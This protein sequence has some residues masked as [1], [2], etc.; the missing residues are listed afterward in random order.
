MELIEA[1]HS[2]KSIR[3]YRPDPVPME[4]VA[5]VLDAA[6]RAPSGM[7]TQPWR[8]WV[9]A[10]AALEG[11]RKENERLFTAG[12]MPDAEMLHKPFTGVYRER[13]VDLAKRIFELMGIPRED[14]DRRTD[15]MKRGFRYFD[16]P[17]AIAVGCDGNM[18]EHVDLLGIGA[19]CQTLCLA[20]LEFGLGTCIA[21]QGIMY[22]EV[23]RRLAGVPEGTRLAAGIAMGYPDP[24]FPANRLL[25]GREPH[26]RVTSWLGFD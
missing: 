16:A 19:L 5:K 3:G 25:T 15:W 14:R 13:Q 17:V 22:G 8:F 18:Y 26:G 4:I 7:N 2:R 1:I 12:T 20:A 24:D 21:D 6:V 11:I 23:W 10:G 9:A